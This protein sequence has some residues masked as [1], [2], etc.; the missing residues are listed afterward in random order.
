MPSRSARPQRASHSTCR[1]PREVPRSLWRAGRGGQPSPGEE[2]RAVATKARCR[3]SCPATGH[4][5][6]CPGAGAAVRVARGRL[7]AEEGAPCRPTSLQP[8]VPR[9]R[10]FCNFSSPWRAPS[11]RGGSP[12]AGQPSPAWPHLLPLQWGWGHSP[13]PNGLSPGC[14]PALCVPT[15]QPCRPLPCTPIHVRTTAGGGPS[16][17]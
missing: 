1:R 7:W 12:C 8:L 6:P 15:L 4:V 11:G 13:F 14:S 10:T 16:V 9:G 2:G 17:P 3:A 5:A